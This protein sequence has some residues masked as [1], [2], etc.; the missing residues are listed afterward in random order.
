MGRETPLSP[1][2][3]QSHG[4]PTPHH[5]TFHMVVKSDCQPPRSWSPKT[6]VKSARLK[7]TW[8]NSPRGCLKPGAAHRKPCER[9]QQKQQHDKRGVATLFHEGDVVFLFMPARTTGAERK[10]QCPTEGPYCITW[11]WSTG[12]E[13]TRLGRKKTIRVALERLRHCPP[14]LL[15]AAGLSSPRDTVAG[16]EDSPTTPNSWT[17]WLRPHV[18]KLHVTRAL[19]QEGG[20]CNLW[21]CD[22]LTPIS[23]LLNHQHPPCLSCDVLTTIVTKSSQ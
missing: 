9:A 6:Q 5:F 1:I 22:T 15:E 2:C 16:L 11:L 23:T 20:E 12:A 8:K 10:L 14:E 13:V 7:D 18:R 21:P 4:V 19:Q 17:H 3:L